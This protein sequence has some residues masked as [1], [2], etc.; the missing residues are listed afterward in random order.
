MS[1]D[2]LAEFSGIVEAIYAGAQDAGSWRG[3]LERIRE[4]TGSSYAYMVY[5]NLHDWGRCTWLVEGDGQGAEEQAAIR[6]DYLDLSPFARLPQ[7]AVTTMGEFVDSGHKVPP[8]FYSRVVRPYGIGDIM[9]TNFIRQANQLATFRVGRARSANRYSHTDKEL[10]R[11][12]LP[13]LH[14]SWEKASAGRNPAWKGVLSEALQ[15]LGVGVV[16]V[17]PDR[18]MLDASATALEVIDT[19][20]ELLTIKSSRLRLHRP[21]DERQLENALGRI[22]S[23]PSVGAQ[24][25]AVGASTGARRLHFVCKPLPDANF[26]HAQPCIAIFIR[27]E[28]PPRPVTTQTLR[29]LFGLTAA[30]ARVACGLIDGL[31]MAQI[32]VRNDISR[33][34]AY[35]HLKAVF[36][37]VGVNQ[38]SALVSHVLGGLASLGRG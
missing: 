5:G 28:R 36:G 37:K 12:L 18:E 16:L 19:H 2:R 13:H 17:D 8:A 22:A 7:D 23:D 32:A 21:P 35:G 10:C 33:N 30:E 27:D 25:F 6:I 4:A 15:T 24:S 1:E 9:G 29:G 3:F 14:R 38:Q 20:R 34:T 26:S 31:S 11:L